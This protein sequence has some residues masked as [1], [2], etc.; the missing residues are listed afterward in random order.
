MARRGFFAELQRQGRIA[1]KARE[2]SEREAIRANVANLRRL[3]RERKE[4][5]LALA[6]WDKTVE[7][8]KKATVRSRAQEEKA[9]AARQKQL[10]KDAREAYLKAKE[11]E[12]EDL[13]MMLVDVYADIDSLLNSTLLRDDFV[14]LTTLRIEVQ[15]PAFDRADLEK[16]DAA[17]TLQP[18]TPQPVLQLPEAPRG[19]ASLF[20]KKKHLIAVESAERAH[21]LALSAWQEDCKQNELR[22][23]S[24]KVKHTRNETDRLERLSKAKS[25]YQ[26]ECRARE[27]EAAAHNRSLEELITNLGYGTVDAVQEYVA[28]VLSSSVY[29]DH[30]SVSHEFKFDP[31]TAELDLRIDIPEP[32]QLPTVK[33]YKY[34]KASD[35]IVAIPLSQKDCRMRYANAVH[36]I[37]LRSF[38][39]VF[40]AD[41][42]GLIQTISLEVGSTTV[43]PAT[44]KREYVPFV[45][46]AAERDT[47]L[48][49]DLSAVV[50]E[51]TL[52]KLGAAVSKNPYILVPAERAGV[53][54]A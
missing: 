1:Q 10:A 45:I 44:G 20:G 51:M 22:W 8:A 46:A 23:Q 39:E 35:E 2:R 9:D 54:R 12:V 29:P 11:A 49:I 32:N 17:P 14:D 37:A 4:A 26:D 52:S 34:V 15:H 13:N 43:D 38:H 18:V 53:R 6:R 30:F 31:E 5:D 19:L 47:F 40:E 16:P 36:Q 42:R 7:A 33:A 50:P 24:E 25:Q 48:E 21:D 41:R 3:E 28:I 27:E